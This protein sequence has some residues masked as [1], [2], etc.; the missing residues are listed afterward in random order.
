[1]VALQINI[2][3]NTLKLI[4]LACGFLTPNV[5]LCQINPNRVSERAF[6]IV[7]VRVLLYTYTL[8]TT[9]FVD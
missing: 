8:L 3:N 4:P 5:L 7:V 1:M 6:L 9:N 2:N